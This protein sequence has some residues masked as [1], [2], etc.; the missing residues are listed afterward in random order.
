MTALSIQPTFPIFTDIDGQPLE[1]G[2]IFIGV[3]NLAPIGNP[4]NVY[5]DAALTLAAVGD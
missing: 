2:Y 1:A 3:A 4:I 5:W